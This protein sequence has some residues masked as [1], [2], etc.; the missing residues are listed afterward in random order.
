[1]IESAADNLTIPF[2]YS[3]V[4][5]YN[6]IR[7]HIFDVSGQPVREL[8]LEQIPAE[9]PGGSSYVYG[10]TWNGRNDRNDYVA[11]GVYIFMV[12]AVGEFHRGK[13][14]LIRNTK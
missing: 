6:R 3:A 13:I 14:A 4:A 5:N 11:S 8:P 2:S 12:D 10:F 7:L 1:M 9:G